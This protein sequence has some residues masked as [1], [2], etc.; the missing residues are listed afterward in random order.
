MVPPRYVISATLL[1][2]MVLLMGCERQSP[3]AGAATFS[4]PTMGTSFTVKIADFP[5]EISEQSLDSDIKRIL[6]RINE[7]MSTYQENS[8]VSR[9]NKLQTTDWFKVSQETIFV[10]NEALRVSDLTQGAFDITVGPLVNLWGF[11]PPRRSTVL[12]SDELIKETQANIGYRLLHTR[13]DPPAIRKEDPQVQIDLS[14]IAKGYAVD[15][16]AEHLQSQHIGNY[17]VEVGGEMRAKGKNAGGMAWKVAIEK[18]ILKHRAVHRVLHLDNKAIATSGNYRNFFE[19]NGV[20]FSHTINP[21]TGKPITHNLASVSVINT[22]SMRAD[23]LAT[24]L[25]VLGPEIGF[26]LAEIENLAVIF[27]VKDTEGFLEKTSSA[28]D[29]SIFVGLDLP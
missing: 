7:R 12:P 29:Q 23:A 4:G 8:E 3:P 25:M 5:E 20:R 9:F 15:Q 1:L 16:I 27:L 21:I 28:L 22:S 14:A 26:Q 24:G 2:E 17:L 18:P 13:D 11:G 10:V 6:T 19:E